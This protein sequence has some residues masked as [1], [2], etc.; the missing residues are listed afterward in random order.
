MFPEIRHLHLSSHDH[1]VSQGFYETY[2]G[3]SFAGIF[4]RGEKSAATVLKSPNGFQ[5]F[6]EVGSTDTLPQ[7]FHCGFLAESAD[8]CLSLYKRMQEDHVKIMNPLIADPFP[9]YFFADPDRHIIQVYFDPKAQL[10][11]ILASS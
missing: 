10:K 4:S 9:S 5:L 6:L 1:I 8:A 3:F 7:W 11:N 2:F